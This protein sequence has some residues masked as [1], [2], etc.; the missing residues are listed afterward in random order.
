[1]QVDRDDFFLMLLRLHDMDM[2]A[3]EESGWLMWM[4]QREAGFDVFAHKE[5]LRRAW[6]S[7]TRVVDGCPAVDKER[8]LQV[9]AQIVN[10]LAPAVAALQKHPMTDE[11]VM[12]AAIRARGTVR[13]KSPAAGCMGRAR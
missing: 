13:A 10:D 2:T 3:H 6:M 8:E 5:L 11:Y 9:L 4:D 12:R 1:M 7:G